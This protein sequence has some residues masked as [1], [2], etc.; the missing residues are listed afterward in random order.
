MQ[1]NFHIFSKKIFLLIIVILLLALYAYYIHPYFTFENFKKNKEILEQFVTAHYYNAALI[2][3]LLYITITA[4]SLPAAFVMSLV[5]GFLFGT[6]FGA[7][8]V[9]TG[10][11]IGATLAFLTIRYS[12][13]NYLQNRYQKQLNNFNR[14]INNYGFF[15]LI[16]VHLFPFIPFFIINI[17]SALTKVSVFTFMITTALGIAPISL[18]YTAIGHQLATMDAYPTYTLKVLFLL[19][20]FALLFLGIFFMIRM[21]KK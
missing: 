2:Y 8:L 21:K 16:I 11:T 7:L 12:T 20:F 14:E 6:F 18:L 1:K 19:F 10:A 4:L 17:L 15:Y 3:C 9:I 13:G 5:G